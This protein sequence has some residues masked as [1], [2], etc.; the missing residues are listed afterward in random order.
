MQVVEAVVKTIGSEKVG[1]RLSP[2][3]DKFLDCTEPDTK[4]NIELNVYLLEQLNAFQLAYVHLVSARSQG[5]P[6]FLIPEIAITL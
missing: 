6:P 2:Y 4:T 1:L 5:A 3:S